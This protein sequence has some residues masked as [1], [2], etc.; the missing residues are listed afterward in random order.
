MCEIS[1]DNQCGFSCTISPTDCILNSSYT[2]KNG[3]TVGQAMHHLVMNFIKVYTLVRRE[4]FY[5]I[6]IEFVVAMQLF[7]LTTMCLN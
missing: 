2:F 5:N 1:G 4:L 3:N 6:L 7:R